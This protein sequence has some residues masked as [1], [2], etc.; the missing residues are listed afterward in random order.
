MGPGSRWVGFVTHRGENPILRPLQIIAQAKATYGVDLHLSMTTLLRA[1]KAAGCEYAPKKAGIEAGQNEHSRPDVVEERTKAAREWSLVQHRIIKVAP[2]A[3]DAVFTLLSSAKKGHVFSAAEQALMNV[4]LR[5][6]EGVQERPILFLNHDEKVFWAHDGVTKEWRFTDPAQ[7]VAFS[8]K[9][10]G[11]GFGSSIMVAMF[12]SVLGIFYWEVTRYGGA[13]N[14]YWNGAR[15]ERHV[16]DTFRY[17]DETFPA[18]R[19]CAPCGASTC[20]VH[21]PSTLP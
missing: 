10:R 5:M 18:V 9:L 13:K 7:E 21:L 14:G 16:E 4:A 20:S 11:K 2:E 17:A 1:V 15:M 19:R 8:S 6:V 3:R 12:M